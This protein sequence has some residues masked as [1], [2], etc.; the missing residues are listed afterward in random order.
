MIN[1]FFCSTATARRCSLMMVRVT[2]FQIFPTI[3]TRTSYYR[4]LQRMQRRMVMV[5]NSIFKDNCSTPTALLFVSS[6][7]ILKSFF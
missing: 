2:K 7:T 4:F 6:M 3:T 5:I 1:Y